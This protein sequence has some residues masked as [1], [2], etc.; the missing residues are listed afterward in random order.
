MSSTIG[1]LAAT[2]L[3]LTTCHNVQAERDRPFVDEPRNMSSPNTDNLIEIPWEEG[4]MELPAYPQESDLLEFQV[5]R[6]ESP[7]RY[8]LDAKSLSVGEA[9]QVVHYTTVII[10]DSGAWNVAHEGMRC[11]AREYKSYAYG[12]GGRWKGE[13]SPEWQKI[14]ETSYTKYRTDLWEYYLCEAGLARSVEGIVRAL[15]SGSQKGNV[16]TFF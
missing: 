3:F 12:V 15:S 8:Y 4:K 9:D 13:R 14:R 5:N 11:D 10:S 1:R 16:P 6:R 2:L 7:F